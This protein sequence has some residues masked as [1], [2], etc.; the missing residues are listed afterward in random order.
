MFVTRCIACKYYAENFAQGT[1]EALRQ[2][3]EHEHKLIS[4]QAK[5][6]WF[7]CCVEAAPTSIADVMQRGKPKVCGRIFTELGQRYP[8]KPCPTCSGRKWMDP[9]KNIDRSAA[10]PL[11][12][13]AFDPLAVGPYEPRW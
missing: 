5:K 1:A 4:V 9:R 2:C 8:S 7:E 13:P 12:V 10:R 6:R 11:T 3:R